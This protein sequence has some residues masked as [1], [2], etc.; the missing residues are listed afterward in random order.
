MTEPDVARLRELCEKATPGP[1]AMLGGDWYGL[2]SEAQGAPS[3]EVDF[4]T[5]H[6]DAEFVAEARTALPWLLDRIAA[7]EA[8]ARAVTIA[9]PELLA[10]FEAVLEFVGVSMKAG[11]VAEVAA[12]VSALRDLNLELGDDA[13]AG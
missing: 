5:Y 1:W 4:S 10:R 9:A 6:A 3:V 8:A 11:D 2:A 7:L 13:R 12:L